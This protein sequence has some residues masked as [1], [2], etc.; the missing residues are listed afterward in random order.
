MDSVYENKV[1]YIN[2]PILL[3]EN[4]SHIFGNGATL[5]LT[6]DFEGEC[7]I[8]MRSE[9]PLTH[10]VVENLRI[11]ASLCNKNVKG[12]IF[13]KIMYNCVFNNIDFESFQDSWIFN[14]SNTISEHIQFNMIQGNCRDK[15]YVNPLIKLDR[16]NESLFVGCKLYGRQYHKEPY[17]NLSL[18][19]LDTPQNVNILSCSFNNTN[20]TAIDI[21]NT[22]ENR[23]RNINIVGCNF[24]DCRGNNTIRIVGSD[25]LI[26]EY[27]SILS[28]G[29]IE[30]EGTIYI[31]NYCCLNIEDFKPN[32]IL[33]SKCRQSVVKTITSNNSYVKNFNNTNT[34]LDY[35]KNKF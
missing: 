34:I 19:T 33:D 17:S 18:F 3:N 11:D 24:E 9:Y 35:T 2:E 1:Y 30:K 27:G 32:I 20:G 14:S 22:K 21:I 4:N 29:Y 25:G 10:M 16:I 6:Q 13:N 31:N 12:I 5:K 23:I 7:V 28:N 26:G 15:I 8:D